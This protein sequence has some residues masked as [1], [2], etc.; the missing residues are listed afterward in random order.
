MISALLKAVN[1]SLGAKESRVRACAEESLRTMKFKAPSLGKA[2][3]ARPAIAL[4][5]AFRSECP[6]PILSHYSSISHDS[7]ILLF[8]LVS[9]TENV[10]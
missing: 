4:H 3:A 1:G 2:E 10:T 9:M 8:L 5:I 6:L 7:H